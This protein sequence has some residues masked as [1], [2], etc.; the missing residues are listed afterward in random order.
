MGQDTEQRRSWRT[1][2]QRGESAE[3]WGTGTRKPEG[4][5]HFLFSPAGVCGLR[6]SRGVGLGEDFREVPL[7]TG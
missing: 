4:A 3:C 1:G 7:V 6:G 5:H 2:G